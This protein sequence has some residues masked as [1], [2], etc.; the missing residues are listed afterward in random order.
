MLC[1]KTFTQLSLGGEVERSA[2]NPPPSEKR[3]PP[4][5][6][7]SSA[8][9]LKSYKRHRKWV[10][11]NRERNREHALNWYYRNREESR[12]RSK[13]RYQ[14]NRESIL[15]K[16]R[17]DANL[18][19]RRKEWYRNNAEKVK[20]KVRARSQTPEGRAYARKYQSR[21]RKENPQ[22]HFMN[23][24]RGSVNRIL[25]DQVQK[26]TGRT[27]E[28]IGCTPTELRAHIES[29][30][31]EGMKWEI[32]RP[33]DVDHIVPVS[34]F[35]VSDPEE[36]KCACN[37]KNLRPMWRMP[38]KYKAASLP[39]PLPPWLPPHIAARIMARNP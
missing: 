11:A 10:E 1:Q 27:I 36:A 33:W 24:L 16:N 14:K 18:K 25:R 7:A 12:R 37:Y 32:P 21:R 13:I 17:T 38:N 2:A 8:A 9:D 28:Y 3:Q 29:Q 19:A 34:L 6:T 20:A 23:W 15:L 26:K 39:S 22:V 30:F 5:E 31:T 35:D 4:E